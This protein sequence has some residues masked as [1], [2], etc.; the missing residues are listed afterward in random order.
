MI[1]SKTEKRRVTLS[2]VAREAGVSKSTVS[3]VLNQSELIKAETRDKVLAAMEVL[4]YVYNR[5]AASLRSRHSKTVGVVID[6][7]T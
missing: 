1:Q 2:D 3:L 4:G 5:S 6:D 7:L